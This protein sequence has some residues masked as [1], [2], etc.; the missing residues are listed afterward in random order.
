M[1]HELIVSGFTLGAC[2]LGGCGGS[3]TAPGSEVSSAPHDGGSDVRRADASDGGLVVEDGGADGSDGSLEGSSPPGCAIS[4]QVGQSRCAAGGV[5]SCASGVDGCPSWMTMGCPAHQACTATGSFSAACICA[6]SICAGAGHTCQDAQ[7][8]V[9]CA[10]DSAGC[11]YASS[12]TACPTHESCSG[13]APTAACA[14]VCTDSCA[15]G[16]ATCVSGGIA[17][18]TLGVNGC[19]A[20]AAPAACPSTN[21]TC[22]GTAGSAACTC[23]VDPACPAP[24]DRCAD[25]STAVSCW[26]DGQGCLYRHSTTVCPVNETCLSGPAACVGPCGPTQ[27]QCNGT[28]VQAC[29]DAWW[30]DQTPCTGPTPHCSNGACVP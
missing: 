18:C 6:A 23:N 8:L 3:A 17:T 2:I 16:Q 15:S 28:T 27:T 5:E 1:R 13:A 29:V 12:A 26:S 10:V 30:V 20:Y 24:V 25:V 11:P 22:R 21:Q 9:T 7:T 19:W 14:L 4:C